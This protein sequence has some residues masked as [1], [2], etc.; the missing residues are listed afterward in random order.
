[1]FLILFGIT[2]LSNEEQLENACFE[3][4]VKEFGRLICSNLVQDKKADEPIF[5]TFAPN[6][7]VFKL[8]QLRKA[9]S[10]IITTLSGITT[11]SNS[12]Q[13]LK[14]LLSIAVTTYVTPLL[15]TSFGIIRLPE[16]LVYPTY[17]DFTLEC[18]GAVTIT[19]E[20]PLFML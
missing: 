11:V 2:I 16:G 18:T 1:M 3:I 15:L 5:F 14:A 7:T 4:S 20:V 10:P 8:L 12:V 9:S 17:E 13:L 6:F 19:V